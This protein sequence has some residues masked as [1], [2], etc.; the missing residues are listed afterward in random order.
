MGTDNVVPASG[1][2]SMASIIVDAIKAFTLL[3]N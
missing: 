1:V 3:E 2:S